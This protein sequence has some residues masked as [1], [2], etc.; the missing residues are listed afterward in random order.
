MLPKRLE[1]KNFLPYRSPD[2][3]VFEN[4][5]LACLSGV[6]GAGKTSLL[7][8]I[9]WSLWGK[10]RARSDDDLIFVGQSD[11]Q[12][13]LDFLHDSRLYRVIRKR[14]AGKL[15]GD[16]RGRSAGESTLDF[17]AWDEAKHTYVLINEPNMR[18]TQSR[19]NNLLRLDYE[20][21]TNSAF[22]QQGKADAFT[23]K[24]PSQRK[25]ILSDILG[26][27]RWA[28]FEDHAKGT[29]RDLQE[30]MR[31]I[32]TRLMEWEQEIAEEPALRRELDTARDQLAEARSAVEHSEE[33][34]DEVKGADVELKST[35]EALNNIRLNQRERE[36]DLKNEDV[37]IARYE[38]HLEHFQA[39]MSEAARIKEG[40]AALETAR[41]VSQELGDKLSV[42]NDL[43][44]HIYAL[45]RQITDERQAIEL[46]MRE[47]QTAIEK[48]GETLRAGQEV[49]SDLRD[50]DIAIAEL[51]DVQAAREASH[52]HIS[53]LNQT[54]AE[55]RT[56]NKTLREEMDEI[57][58][59][60]DMLE[61]SHEAICP[62][63]GQPLDDEHRESVMEQTRAEGIRR[64]DT[65][66]EN[67]THMEELRAEIETLNGSIRAADKRLAELPRLRG[68]RGGYEQRIET[69]HEAEIRIQANEGYLVQLTQVLENG[70]FAE[71]VRAQ[72][73][74]ALQER[75]GLGYDGAAHAAAREQL[76][77]Y[78]GYQ[79]E[80][81]KLELAQQSVPQIQESLENAR[82][83]RERWIKNL[84]EY[85]QQTFDYKEQI[86]QLEVKFAE[87][88]RRQDEVNRQ[89]TLLRNADEKVI[90]IEQG[91]RSIERLKERRAM[92]I[93]RREVLARQEAVYKQLQIAF[94]RNGIPAML[95]EAAIPEL[96]E[97][98][99]RMLSR[100]TNNRMH[101]RF[102]TQ[103]EMKMGGV[104]ETLDIWIQ[105]ELGQRDYNMFSGGEAFRVNFAIRVA[106]SQL[107]ARRAG[108]QLRTLFI[109]EGFGTQDDSGRERLVE[110]ITA[111]QDDFDLILVIT[112]IDE[113]KDA[114]PARIEVIKT[115]NGSLA[116]V[117]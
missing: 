11:M 44:Q 90:S 71:A 38:E 99:N 60:L 23:T 73:S 42:L 15:R 33:M 18:E 103:R 114:F 41:Q 64:G 5:H 13:T 7:D 22:L 115:N 19:I 32:D 97:D 94:G 67:N 117:R 87:M 79:D 9:T 36:K 65:F 66:R 39:V 80:A 8:A 89:R 57:K 14:R 100:M 34:L 116:V 63:C 76:D 20:V 3:I 95:I 25:D 85:E 4:L 10:A 110:A 21:F 108:A 111:I 109:D 48:D 49:E 26:L 45:E 43:N 24:T 28:K 58:T 96:E 68:Q 112:H 101:L 54:I 102:D 56:A 74:A 83:R 55:L 69:A 62:V 16:G 17:F 77:T 6:N 104:A 40:Y 37:E 92:E 86:E 88:R 29:L 30:Q 91:M 98:A 81:Q 105:D 93:E 50:L 1:L 53:T 70:T 27:D 113:L 106:L 61:S 2:P 59:R 78:L 84:E 82:R 47:Y 72:L 52:N 12:V 35:Q 51:E 31:M 46:E 75:D 107:L